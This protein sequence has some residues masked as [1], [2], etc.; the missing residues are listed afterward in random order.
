M[1]SVDSALRLDEPPAGIVVLSGTML[2]EAN[3]SRLIA[4]RGGLWVVQSHGHSDP[5]LPYSNALALRDAFIASG[6][7]VQFEDF[8]GGHIIPEAA[9]HA[10]AVLIRTV[11]RRA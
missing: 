3:W 4:K 8:A 1:L 2:D 11:V 7:R 6:C 9:V 5:I 10:C